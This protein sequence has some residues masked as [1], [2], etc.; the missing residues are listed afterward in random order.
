[1]RHHSFMSALVFLVMACA[2]TPAPQPLANASVIEAAERAFAAD[3]GQRGWVESFRSHAAPDAVVIWDDPANA[4]QQLAS[5][6]AAPPDSSLRWHPLWVGIARSGDFGFST[7]PVISG[8]RHSQYF[9]IWRKDADGTWKWIYDGG[10]GSSGPSQFAYDAPATRAP[11]AAESTG[12]AADREIH[13][14]EEALANASVEDYRGALRAHLAEDGRLLG[15]RAQPAAGAAALD[16]E[17]ASRPAKVSMGTLGYAQSSAG[18]MA[19]TYGSTL[20][21]EDGEIIKRG[22]YVRVWRRDAPGW[23]IVADVFLPKKT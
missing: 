12:A 19:Y 18:D 3:A 16:A 21:V 2:T 4:Q 20:W 6:P 14:L 5:Q 13:A 22:Y 10:F 17:L 7:G 15:S 23:R 9:S 8:D 1:M 11:L